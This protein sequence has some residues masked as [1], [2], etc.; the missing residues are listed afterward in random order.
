MGLG[1]LKTLWLPILALV[2]AMPAFAQSC[3]NREDV[4]AKL[5]D[6]YGEHLAFRGLQKS[7]GAQ[8]ILEVWVSTETGS[9]TVLQT[10]PDG[11][12]CIVS[13]GTHF[14]EAKAPEVPAGDP[15]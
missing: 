4:I 2:L 12:S 15:L 8:T 3:A 7:R 6:S 10:R 5:Q 13:A 11:I 14:F 1:S 9:F